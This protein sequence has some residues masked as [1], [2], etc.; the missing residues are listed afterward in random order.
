MSSNTL[1]QPSRSFSQV[2][3]L[4]SGTFLMVLVK[5]SG[6]IDPSLVEFLHNNIRTEKDQR[7]AFVEVELL[8]DLVMNLHG[9]TQ[10]KFQNCQCRIPCLS[11]TADSVNNALTLV[12]R[13][14]EKMR[15]GHGGSGFIKVYFKDNDEYWKPLNVLRERL[16]KTYDSEIK[17]NFRA[18]FLKLS[19]MDRID[20]LSNLFNWVVQDDTNQ[21]LDW[22]KNLD[23]NNLQKLNALI[24]LSHLQN[25]IDIWNKN[26][27][28]TEE[29]FWQK[30]LVENSF[31][32][33]QVFS[34]PVIL[35]RDKVYVGGKG[36][37]NT[38]GKIVDFLYTNQLTKNT[39]IIEI[40]TPKAK[41]LGNLYRDDIYTPSSEIS[42]ALIQVSNYKNILLKKFDSLVD[43]EKPDIE[44]FNPSCLLIVGN[45]QKEFSNHKQRQ[46]FELFRAN[47]REVQIITFDEL[48]GKIKILIDLL[49]GNSSKS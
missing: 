46:S 12:S 44:A 8:D 16:D 9:V 29:E 2:K 23:V 15:R 30:I 41:I 40:K 22:L 11:E 24:G 27:D 26:Q 48:F 33:S 35:F 49:E 31:I 20:I 39:A 36:F 47:Q 17:Q 34:I 45:M 28:N 43:S 5:P 3:F 19:K 37:S 38:G 10:G 4:S 6:D 32:L 21:I 13:T 7:G 42:G 14:Y 1:K 18:T 25:V